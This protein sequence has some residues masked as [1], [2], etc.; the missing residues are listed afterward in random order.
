MS[1]RR[2]NRPEGF[3]IIEVLIVIV[4]IGILLTVLMVRFINS[5]ADARDVD[6]KAD[7]E[8]IAR[9]F[10]QVFTDRLLSGAATYPRTIDITPE[11][12]VALAGLGKE[13]LRSPKVADSANMS[14]IAATNTTA[15]TAGVLPQPTI[16]Q[17]VYQPLTSTNALCNNAILTCVKFNL[18]YRTEADNTVIQVSSLNQ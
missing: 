14:L 13:A 6:R 12:A 3:T 18:Y 17:Y 8:T 9:R 11:S 2:L 5:Q 1:A 4:I 16:D 15:T 7:I 10:E